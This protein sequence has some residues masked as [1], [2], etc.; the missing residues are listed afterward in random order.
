MWFTHDPETDIFYWGEEEPK[1]GFVRRKLFEETHKLISV[2]VETISLKERIAVGVGISLTPRSSFYFPL[3]PNQCSKIP[4]HLLQDPSVTKVFHG[5]LFDLSALREYDVDTT[6]II[7]T[8]TMSRLL[9]HKYSGLSELTWLHEMEAHDMKGVLK[10]YNARTTM[11]LPPEVCAKKCMQDTSATLQLYY[12]MVDRVDPNYLDI[13]MQLIPIMIEMS[14]RGILIDQE[15]REDVEIQLQEQVDFFHGLCEEEGFSPGS[16]QQVAYTLAKRGAYKVFSRLPWTNYK[17][18]Q[19]ATDVKVL[20]KMDDPLASIVLQ[21]RKHNKLLG[22]YVKPWAHSERATTRFHTD[23]ITG[24]PSS[25]DRN[26]QNIPGKYAKDGSLNQINC[27]AILLPDT[28]V[29][30]DTDFVGLEPRVLAYLSGDK[31][32]QY[33]FSLPPKNPDGTKNE[34]ADIH[35]Q[36]GNFMEVLRRLGKLINLAMSYGATDQTLMELAG[37]RDIGR[38]RQLRA[39]WGQKFPGAMDYIESVQ[40]DALITGRSKTVFGREIRLPTLDEESE[41]SIKRKAVNYPCQASA[42]EI[43]KRG[44]IL[45]KDL[46]LALQ[47]HDEILVDGFIPEY[48]FKPLES[49]APFQTPIDVGYLDRWE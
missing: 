27:R 3:F 45:M 47:V 6:N 15:M 24:R 2:D 30:T 31:E 8:D 20:E 26:M 44:L 38:A 11:E 13:E 35:L 28:G 18:T 9:C 10:E 5:P 34:A 49:I 36:V 40:H 41:D 48:R 25:T 21:H 17:K 22:T 43:L 37:I 39:M 19:L 4:W 12:K 7:G 14:N 42:A 23:A 33:I 32:M 46:P 1:P 16:P 29:W